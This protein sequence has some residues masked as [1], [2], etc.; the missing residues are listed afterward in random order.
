[1]S[2]Q[3]RA[4]KT[5][6]LKQGAVTVR[7]IRRSKMTEIMEAAGF[8]EG[9]TASQMKFAMLACRWAI[10]GC[11]GMGVDFSKARH[12]TLGVIASESVYDAISDDD[13]ASVIEAAMP[14]RVDE[15]TEGN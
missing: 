9:D 4:T 11:E 6:D 5:V 15:E 14:G 7:E 12:R 3:A 1:M 2:I 13:I 10:V 8:R